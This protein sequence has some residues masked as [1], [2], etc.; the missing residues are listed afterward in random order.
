MIV[1]TGKK[2]GRNER[3]HCGSG[4][5][6]KRCC[7]RDDA[8]RLSELLRQARGIEEQPAQDEAGQ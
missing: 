3:C 5:K 4:K 8:R 2:I 7:M 6:Y 1:R